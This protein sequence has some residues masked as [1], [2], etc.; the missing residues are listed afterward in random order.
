MDKP[1]TTLSESAV[2][3]LAW[4][5]ELTE[6]SGDPDA[7]VDDT[8]DAAI[9]CLLP[10][11]SQV[12]Q[13]CFDYVDHVALDGDGDAYVSERVVINPELAA[14]VLT[15]EKICTAIGN[16]V[17]TADAQSIAILLTDYRQRCLLAGANEEALVPEP[18]Y[19]DFPY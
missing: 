14:A 10:A 2:Q 3:C 1:Y 15:M 6:T 19:C 4:L 17:T 5:L 9:A 13:L 18:E 8:K 12:E 7:S 11:I 16:I